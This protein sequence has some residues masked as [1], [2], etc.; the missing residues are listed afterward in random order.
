M[1]EMIQGNIELYKADPKAVKEDLKVFLRQDVARGLI[2]TANETQ[3]IRAKPRGITLPGS[4]AQIED[5][6]KV[7]ARRAPSAMNISQMNQYRVYTSSA[8]TRQ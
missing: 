7:V 8:K 1:I 5:T 4:V 6:F 2:T 3:V